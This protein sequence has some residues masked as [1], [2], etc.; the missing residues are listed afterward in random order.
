MS[1]KP[2]NKPSFTP[3]YSQIKGLLLQAMQAGEWKPGEMMP[4]EMELALRFEVSQGTV[5]KAI[6]E[7]AAS[8]HVVRRQGKGTFVASHTEQH[9][10]YRF[11]RLTPDNKAQE[12]PAERQILSCERVRASADVARALG[13][14]TNDAVVHAERLL[15]FAGVPTI[16][17]TMWLPGGP[18]KG[19]T[20]NQL[21]HHKGSTY[22]L[23]EEAFG[24]SM[25]RAEEQ[26]RASAADARQAALLH[27]E[28]GTPLLHIER[29]AYTYQNTAMELRQ[30]V[31]LTTA[32]HYRNVLN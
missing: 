9:A 31:W 4:S 18:F 13:L 7:L 24:V 3:L 15:S 27:I 5:R 6:D 32:H 2:S 8:H 11:L 16:I 19:L 14:K 1:D 25:L 10:P 22:G 29:L 30:A 12:S 26:I 21:A 20:A 23:Y 28:P 17:E